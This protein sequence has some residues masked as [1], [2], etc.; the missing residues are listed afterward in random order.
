MQYFLLYQE[1]KY[2]LVSSKKASCMGSWCF[3]VQPGAGHRPCSWAESR[4]SCLLYSLGQ[5]VGAAT[6]KSNKSLG[7]GPREEQY[8]PECQSA[9]Q[10]LGEERPWQ[11]AHPQNNSS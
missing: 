11:P 5:E 1:Y 4:S 10:L 9:L 2:P 8:V 7:T 6:A 3:S